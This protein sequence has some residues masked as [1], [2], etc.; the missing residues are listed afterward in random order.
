M[1]RADQ[2]ARLEPLVEAQLPTVRGEQARIRATEFLIANRIRS[3]VHGPIEYAAGDMWRIDKPRSLARYL[4]GFLFFAD[5]AHTLIADPRVSR[6][7]ADVALSLVDDW[8][9]LHGTKRHDDTMAY[10]DETTAQRLINLL[11]LRRALERSC[12]PAHS[13]ALDEVIDKTALILDDE[14]FHAG[15]N[16]HGMFQDL[17]LVYWSSLAHREEAHLR[18]DRFE[19][20][21]ARLQKYFGSAFT[22]EGVH[23]ENSPTY[24]L[25]VSRYAHDVG[26]LATAADMYGPFYTKLVEKAETYAIHAIMPNG[27]FPPISDTKQQELRQSGATRFFRT[28]EFNFASSGGK[29]GTAPTKRI[30]TLPV[31]GYAIYR[32]DW[33]P[34]ATF[35]FFS[36]AYNADYHKHSDDLSF[37]LR[38]RGIDLISEAGPYSYDYKD[39]LSKYAYSQFAH[40]SLV[41]DGISLPRTDGR[42]DQVTLDVLDA[43]EGGFDVVGRNGRYRDV[44]HE[45]RVVVSEDEGVPSFMLTDTIK[46][47]SE[48]SYQLLWNLGTDVEVVLHAQGFELFHAGDKMMDLAFSASVATKVSLHEGEMKPY[49]LGWRFPKFGEAIPAKV[50]VVRFAGSCVRVE[51]SVRLADFNYTNRGAGSDLPSW[52]RY[53]GEVPVTYMFVPGRSD[54]GRSRLA[55]AF[56]AIGQRGDFT[57]NYK[58]TLDQLDISCL[59]ILDDFGSQGAYYHSDHRS[60][61]IYRTVQRLILKVCAEG[62]IQPANVATVGSSKGG[63]AALMHG[64]TL[65]AGR[66]IVGAPQTRVG[67][68]LA[69]PHPN[70]LEYMAG[71]T[72]EE[73]VRHLDSIVFEK[74]ENSGEETAISVL[75]GAND[76]H[77]SQ[78]V[79]PLME[80]MRSVGAPDPILTVLPDLSHADIGGIYRHFLTAN[81]EQWMRGSQ[82]EA[83]PYTLTSLPGDKSSIRLKL[84]SPTDA[85][86]AYRLFKENEVIRRRS[87]SAKDV[88]VFRDVGPGRYRIRVFIKMGGSSDASAFTTRWITL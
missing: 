14:K 71:G 1:I 26:L 65:G 11:T 51:T 33:T 87:Y 79:E 40:N 46:S 31:S 59:Y 35:S 54:A 7:A 53:Q 75:V 2:W 74:L 85:R 43:H 20:A 27:M 42:N 63:A 49:P 77:L 3:A 88:V 30:L 76:H 73:D 68:F 64:S 61:A 60:E 78:H 6:E 38:S 25:M 37:F 16:N 15:L 21:M 17:G 8:Q 36:A 62:Q 86:I 10:H 48:H 24:H 9:R 13:R 4:H 5:W 80:H 19:R 50:V 55:V 34:E 18:S 82:E 66:I 28:A 58:A 70:I 47:D 67:T 29:I 23:I 52:C 69:K 83:L 41:V 56:S 32:S 57:Y 39:P 84:Y 12:L 81:L 45:R 44:T 72:A 22:S